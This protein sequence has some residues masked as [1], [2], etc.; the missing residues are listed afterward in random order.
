M[1]WSMLTT[2]SPRGSTARAVGLAMVLALVVGTLTVASS[3][4]QE[5]DCWP[6]DVPTGAIEGQPAPVFCL[7]VNSGEGTAEVAGNSWED[8]FDHGLSFATFDGTGYQVFEELGSVEQSVHWRHA[9]HWMVDLA[10]D[11]QS[12]TGRNA[13]GGAM[14]RPDTTFRF[15]DGKLV[16]EADFAAGIPGYQGGGF[17]QAWGEID[18]TTAAAPDDVGRVGATYGYDYFPG[19]YTLGC[20]FQV[21]SNVTCSLMDDSDQNFFT[22]GR[23]WEMSFFQHVGTSVFGGSD[24][25]GDGE[26]FEECSE[27]SPDSECRSRWRLELTETSLSVFINEQLY[28]EQT[29]IPPL[30]TELFDAELYVYASSITGAHDGDAIRYH[31]DRFAV[32]PDAEPVGP[33]VDPP[34]CEPS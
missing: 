10:P 28:F 18:I 9:D 34:S 11:P 13:R 4:A 1:S 20:R 15:D 29:G 30:P 23:I 31:W 19:H 25:V 32:N 21:D 5:P 12:D 2:K 22:T 14:L 6:V 33:P 17:G 7:V 3:Q 16:V 26:V 24:F 27:G 8:D